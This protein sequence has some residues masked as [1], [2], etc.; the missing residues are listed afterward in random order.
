MALFIYPYIG[1]ESVGGSAEGAFMLRSLFGVY[2]NNT[3]GS[4]RRFLF[5]A[6]LSLCLQFV[7]GGSNPN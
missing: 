1:K 3:W 4:T 7:S 6:I 2:L 5:T